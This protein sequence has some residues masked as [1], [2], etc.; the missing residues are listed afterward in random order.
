MSDDVSRRGYLKGLGSLTAATLAGCSEMLEGGHGT[1]HERE[2][3]R[4][5]TETSTF[6]PTPTA[7]MTET[8]TST[9]SQ[10]TTATPET[11]P[12]FVGE[13]DTIKI[14]YTV[15]AGEIGIERPGDYV[16]VE[17][18]LDSGSA[19]IRVDQMKARETLKWYEDRR[20]DHGNPQPLEEGSHVTAE[21]DPR[22]DDMR[23]GQVVTEG[24]V[25]GT[26]YDEPG[27][28]LQGI[29]DK[30]YAPDE[31]SII[32]LSK[33]DPID[34]HIRGIEVEWRLLDVAQNEDEPDVARM[35]FNGEEYV[36]DGTDLDY[37]FPNG[38][39]G[40]T[41]VYALENIEED[42]LDIKLFHSI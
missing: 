34:G 14:G 31:G 38:R 11:P 25:K 37:R 29:P 3:D 24:E 32:D 5:T 28:V 18:V 23:V 21:D 4:S 19:V 35:E 33:E 27:V 36:M 9:D 10:E 15:E 40:L 13:R 26:E 8:Q 42:R 2:E 12:V 30:D 22:V 1:V 41:F 17:E 7:T 6:T 39:D 16:T 20:I